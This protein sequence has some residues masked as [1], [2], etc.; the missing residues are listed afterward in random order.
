MLNNK[1]FGENFDIVCFF[2]HNHN[3]RKY[4]KI[5]LNYQ[6]II[7]SENTIH[8]SFKV[9]AIALSLLYLK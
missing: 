6:M 4:N 5:F 1:L 8:L 7:F 9:R 3:W 2:I